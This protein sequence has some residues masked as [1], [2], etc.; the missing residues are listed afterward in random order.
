MLYKINYM[1]P[2]DMDII[3]L[4]EEGKKN[5]GIAE[6]SFTEKEQPFF[7]SIL[8]DLVP[9]KKAEPKIII[10]NGRNHRKERQGRQL[11]RCNP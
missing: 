10:K 11:R 1:V 5:K 4:E 8:E 3:G 2:E 6:F 9:K 7:A